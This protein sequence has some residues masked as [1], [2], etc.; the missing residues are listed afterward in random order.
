MKTKIGDKKGKK[1][2]LGETFISIKSDQ[3][4]GN[5]NALQKGPKKPK[6]AGIKQNG[7]PVI[8]AKEPISK[9]VDKQKKEQV[10]VMKKQSGVLIPLKTK[11]DTKEKTEETVAKPGKEIG[12]RSNKSRKRRPYLHGEFTVEQITAKIAE[13]KSREVLSKRAKR[14]LSILNRKLMTSG[15]KSEKLDTVGKKSGKKAEIPANAGIS[16]TV[17]Q[18]INVIMNKKQRAEKKGKAAATTAPILSR[19]QEEDDSSVEEDDDDSDVEEDDDSNAEIENDSIIEACDPRTL[20]TDEETD[21]S[22]SE[23]EEMEDEDEE[24][25]SEDDE[26]EELESED[27]EDEEIDEEEDEDEEDEDETTDEDEEDTKTRNNKTVSEVR[28]GEAQ[29]KQKQE[30]N[31]NKQELNKN[32]QE[33]NKNIQEQNKN[34]KVSVSLD[35]LKADLKRKRCVLFVGNLPQDITENE[36][37][38][39]FSSKVSANAITNIILPTKPDNTPRGFGYVEFSNNVDFEK[40]LSLHHTFLKKKRINVEYSILG[41]KK[42]N[43][44]KE[45]SV[46]QNM[47]PQAFQKAGKFAGGQQKKKPFKKNK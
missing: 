33:Q 5:A 43:V 13:I 20:P 42:I 39:H 7:N 44:T 27:E 46:A 34:K 10:K 28:K 11:K 18:R 38:Q 25:E 22:E 37:K 19:L 24:V 47:K 45:S 41:G 12:S 2:P 3:S 31:K 36:I 29:N 14:I 16:K 15:N 8:G 17:E 21:E 23:D 26:D 4:Q 40:G 35:Q 6:F 32:K 30:Q 9:V 1:R